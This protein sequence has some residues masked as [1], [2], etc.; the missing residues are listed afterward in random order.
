MCTRIFLG[1]L[2][3]AVLVTPAL[4]AQAAAIGT[5]FQLDLVPSHVPKSHRTPSFRWAYELQ[6]AQAHTRM[7]NTMYASTP[8]RADVAPMCPALVDGGSG[9]PIA[10]DLRGATRLK[11]APESAMDLFLNHISGPIVQAKCVN[12]HV[13]GGVS[14][15]TRLIFQPSSTPDHETRNLATFENFLATV[16][17]GANQI[18]NKIQGVGHG[19]GVQVV[20]GSADFDNME[21]FL[22]LLG[23]GGG[24]DPGLSP[25]TLFDAVTMASP[26]RTLRRAALIFG[27]RIPTRAELE[28]VNSTDPADLRAGIRNLM[29]GTGFHKFLIRASND[30]LLTDRHLDKVIDTAESRFVDFVNLNWM[31]AMEAIEKGYSDPDHDLA[32]DRW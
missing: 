26:E 9:L 30:R 2:S 17:D 23:Y 15:H 31:K 3:V 19:G 32:Y 4:A 18:L 21:S 14:G 11:S 25:K 28:A 8:V 29:T 20:A 13:E 16:V 5:G 1:I 22:R 10:L 24:S 6:R 12:C 7:K 27:E